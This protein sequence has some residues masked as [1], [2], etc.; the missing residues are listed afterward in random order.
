MT[1]ELPCKRRRTESDEEAAVSGGE[2]SATNASNKPTGNTQTEQKTEKDSG[3]CDMDTSN[4]DDQKDKS[5]TKSESEQKEEEPSTSTSAIKK[6][7][8][9]KKASVVKERKPT[10][11]AT[12]VDMLYKN[13]DSVFNMTKKASDKGSDKWGVLYYRGEIT[14]KLNHCQHAVWGY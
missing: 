10:Q 12:I 3:K 4:S 11:K 9:S 5:E 1:D 14:T 6:A 13:I 7:P 2:E 8:E